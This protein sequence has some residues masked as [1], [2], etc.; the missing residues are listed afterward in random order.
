[1]KLNEDI[2]FMAFR[3]ALGRATYVVNDVVETLILHWD[4]ISVNMK[5]MIQDE[6]KDAIEKD[7]AGWDIDK[8]EWK[9]ILKLNV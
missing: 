8:E 1:M 6:I 3:Y 7:N 4:E 2:L 5:K 9:K